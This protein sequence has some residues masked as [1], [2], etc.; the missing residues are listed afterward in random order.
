MR[1]VTHTPPK[2]WQLALIAAAIYVSAP[3]FA[4]AYYGEMLRKGAYPPLADSIGIPIYYTSRAAILLG[5]VFC[6]LL[7]L[8]LW[9]YPGSVPLFVWNP[10]RR[11]WSWA[12]TG[13]FAVLI[14]ITATGL[15]DVWQWKLPI[16]FVNLS[17]W[18]WLLLLFRAV[19]VARPSVPARRLTSA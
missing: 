12:C 16:E 1:F 4:I 19:L 15:V 10:T 17:L 14:A 18:I 9:R 6:L 5:P 2:A 13:L 3:F 11:A 8:I 7:I